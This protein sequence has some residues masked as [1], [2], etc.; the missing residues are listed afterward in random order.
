[1]DDFKDRRP[2]CDDICWV[3]AQFSQ[4]TRITYSMVSVEG[5]LQL[6]L[7]AAELSKSSCWRALM[8]NSAREVH[9]VH[10]EVE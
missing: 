9:G 7:H 5:S 6:L 3:I 10:D 2:Y 8:W 1:M 4:G